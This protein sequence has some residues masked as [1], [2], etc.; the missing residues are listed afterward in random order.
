MGAADV[1]LEGFEGLVAGTSADGG[2][3]FAQIDHRGDVGSAG[4]VG[5]DGLPER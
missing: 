2:V 4:C 3:W 5:A 1:A